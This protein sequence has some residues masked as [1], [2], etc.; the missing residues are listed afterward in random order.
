VTADGFVYVIGC[1][2]HRAVKIGMTHRTP[3]ARAKDM[4]YTIGP[5]A[6][7][8]LRSWQTDDARRLEALLHQRLCNA[9][10]RGEWFDLDLATI[11]DAVQRTAEAHSLRAEQ[12]LT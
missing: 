11:T 10:L 3:S 7:Q 8:V 2:G 1:P 6:L 5:V 4:H 12:D 9:R